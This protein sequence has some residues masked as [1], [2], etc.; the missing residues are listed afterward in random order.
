M[1]VVQTRSGK[2]EGEARD[3]LCVFKG[4]PYA[5]PPVG[6]LRWRA[7]E[8]VAPWSGVRAAT[9]VGAAAPQNPLAGG[10]LAAFNVEEATSEDCLYLN[11]WTPAVD[12]G[13]RPVLV[14]IHG[15]GFVIGSGA[16]RIY[17]GAELARRGDVVVVTINY[18]L[19]P[20]GFLR[21]KELTRG[22]IPSTGNEGLLDQVAALEWVQANVAAFGGDPDNVTIFGESAGGMS[23]TTLLALPAARGLFRKAIA[24]SGAGHSAYGVDVHA[25][26][27]DRVLAAAG[28]RDASALR[29]LTAAQLLAASAKVQAGAAQDPELRG[30]MYQ[31]VLDGE[32]LPRLP[33][34]DIQKGSAAGVPL[35]VGTTL[36]EWKLFALVDPTVSTLSEAG[37][38][39]RLSRWLGPAAKAVVETY[40]KARLERGEPIGPRD[41]Y[42]AIETDRCFRIPSVRLAEAQGTHS[43]SVY[44][45]L[46]TWKSPLWNGMLG[47]CHS[48]ELGFVFG[49]LRDRGIGQFAGSG[50]QA[51]ELSAK[52]MDSWIAFARS[53]DPST[54][55]LSWPRY[56]TAERA[57]LVLGETCA[58]ALAPF[59]EERRAWQHAPAHALGQP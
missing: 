42:L 53:G 11:V 47:A 22:E 16:Q 41:L 49:T 40:R 20:L 26:V 17:D 24:Q 56:T 6:P 9:T 18:R 31:P 46:F 58:T 15:G 36:E 1:P 8:P 39:E 12:A 35:L 51:E 48:I 52:V 13:R 34:E 32:I 29:A 27:V 25:R 5:A 21:L 4:I 57:T 50:P 59:D 44:A 10:I 3:G 28:S 33:I 38:E 45:Y 2:L 19:G 14:W 54:R 30:L 37:L 23:V 43:P 7:P 55:S